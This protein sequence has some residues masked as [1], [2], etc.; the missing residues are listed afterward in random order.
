MD[1]LIGKSVPRREDRRFLTG[2]GCFADDFNLDGQAHACFVRSP[3]AHA[4]VVNI[5]IA[6]ALAA[7][8]VI[9]ILTGADYLAD[10]NGP[11]NHLVIGV[12]YDDISLPGFPEEAFPADAPPP[13]IP[14]ATDRVRHVGDPIVIVIAE[15]ALEAI[16]ATEQVVADYEVL[17]AVTRARDAI[18]SDAPALFDGGNICVEFSRGDPAATEAAFA[19]ASHVVR[20]ESLSQRISAIPIE[21]RAAAA[22]VNPESGASSQGVHKFKLA[23]MSSLGLA[24]EKIRVI[25]HDV[26]G[27]F[28]ARSCSNGEYPLLVWAAQ[29]TG[30]PVKWTATRSE[31]FLADYQARDTEADAAL[32][33]D[34]DGRIRGLRI[35]YVT[36]LGAYPVSFAVSG[37]LQRLA[38]GPYDIAAVHMSGRA[39]VTNTVPVSVYRGAGRPEVT[40]IV[41]RLLDMAAADLGIDRVEIRRRNLISPAALPYQTPLG[42]RYDSGAF[43]DNL[44]AARAAIDWDGFGARR[45][46][47]AARGRIAGIGIATYLESPAGAPSERA[48]IRVRPDGRIEAIVGTQSTGQG[49][50][51]VFAQVVADTLQVPD[52]RIDIAFGD[53]GISVSGGGT[54]SDRSMRLGGTVLVRAGEAVIAHGREMASRLLET[55]E[56]DITYANS[57]F[58]VAGTDREIDLFDLAAR[59]AAADA[60]DDIAGSLEGSDTLAGRLPAHPNGVAACEVEIDPETGA[61]TL[62]RYATVDDV[63]RVINPV[64]VDGQIHGGIAQGVGQALFE[65]NAIDAET[66]Q[67]LAGSFMDYTMPR[68][69][70]LPSFS[71]TLNEAHPAPSNPLGV[72][73]AGEAGTTPATAAIVSAAVDALRER[74]VRHIETPLTSERLLRALRGADATGPITPA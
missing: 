20:L 57:R 51:T 2:T 62:V 42:P 52:D 66:G 15:S 59:M 34:R 7:P 22:V 41:E 56:A 8:G 67:I 72:K 18:A 74:G 17:P 1:G 40:F 60:P 25:T 47:A 68:A 64:I 16:D 53:S 31:T 30:R 44:E 13:H 26:G 27:G 71:N 63:G 23:V 61:L 45:A 46:A 3:H 69:D 33:L 6:A 58:T 49:H 39:V 73:G 14:I 36:N 35:D 28:G 12:D 19:D 5:D 43:A 65:H 54:H 48:D 9:A 32:A 70:D 38:G 21:P 37:N 11:I 4:R 55:A 50:E 10:G 29:R 24:P